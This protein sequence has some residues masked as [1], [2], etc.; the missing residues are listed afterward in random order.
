MANLLRTK[1]VLLLF[2]VFSREAVILEMSKGER[3]LFPLGV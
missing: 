3:K 1:T 2:V